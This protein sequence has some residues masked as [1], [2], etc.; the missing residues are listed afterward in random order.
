MFKQIV[1]QRVLLILENTKLVAQTSLEDVCNTHKSQIIQIVSTTDGSLNPPVVENFN[2]NSSFDEL[3]D[4][5]S[6]QKLTDGPLN[7]SQI[8]ENGKKSKN[9]DVQFYKL[10]ESLWPNGKPVAQPK[11]NDI[12][13]YLHLIPEADHNFYTSL[14]G[15]PSIE[16]DIYGYNG[17]LDFDLDQ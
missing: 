16:E 14:I 3:L 1:S 9:T 17:E 13:S 10:L 5:I 12:R 2:K 6:S 8:V 7:Y 11:L 15:D 4:D